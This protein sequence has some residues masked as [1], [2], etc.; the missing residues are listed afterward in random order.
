MYVCSA[1]ILLNKGLSPYVRAPHQTNI[2]SETQVWMAEQKDKHEKAK[3]QELATQYQ[4]EQDILT[5]R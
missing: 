5:N 1:D 4:R 2:C 3:Q